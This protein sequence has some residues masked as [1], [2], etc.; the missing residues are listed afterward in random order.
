M[1]NQLIGSLNKL[2]SAVEQ[3]CHGFGPLFRNILVAQ[4]KKN[5]TNKILVGASAV[6]NNTSPVGL[7]ANEA[8]S[9][10][11]QIRK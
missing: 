8:M 1:D 10:V 7:L 9:M 11:L 4:I 2:G 5:L 3:S 6:S